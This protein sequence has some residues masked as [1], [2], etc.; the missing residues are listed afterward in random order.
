MGTLTSVLC[1]QVSSMDNFILDN[2][3]ITFVRVEG[4]PIP[5]HDWTW[6]NLSNMQHIHRWADILWFR[7]QRFSIT[8]IV[9]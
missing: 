7:W 4:G 8:I 6:A 3:L 2:V 9:V 1:E 5:Q